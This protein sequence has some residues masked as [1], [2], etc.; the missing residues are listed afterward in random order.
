MRLQVLY[1]IGPQAGKALN[2]ISIAGIVLCGGRSTRMGQEKALLRFGDEV[3]VQRMA[4]IVGSV[5]EI[6]VVVAANDQ[7]LPTFSG[8]VEVARDEVDGRGPMQGLV[9]GLLALRGRADAAYVTSCDAPFLRAE[10]IRRM[11]S[12]LGDALICVPVVGGFRHPLAAACR[13]EIADIARQLIAAGK[14]SLMQLL[15]EV[16]SRVVEASELADVDPA[17]E[18]LRNV[19]TPQEYEAALRD[20][21]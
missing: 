17:L 13:V 6:V 7:I 18:S 15:D 12:L 21:Y 4:R 19:N 10:F 3:L 9:A 2:M 8:N 1:V 20:A 16:P 11:M 14:Y 5:A